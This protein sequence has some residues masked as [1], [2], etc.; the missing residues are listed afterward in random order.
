M[1]RIFA[2][3]PPF[4]DQPQDQHR[5]EGQTARFPCNTPAVPTA[6]INWYKDERPVILDGRMFILP[7]GALE[8]DNIR[9]S[10]AGGYKCRAENVEGGKFSSVGR[11]I[12]DEDP[13]NQSSNTCC[14]SNAK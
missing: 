14:N 5:F 3:L 1:K 10:D 6:S 11:L 7:S 12:M 9:S 2:A 13:G 8:I 4:E